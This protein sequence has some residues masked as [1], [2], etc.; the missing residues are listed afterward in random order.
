M[1]P[2]LSPVD[3]LSAAIRRDLR[4]K[5]RELTDHVASVKISTNASVRREHEVAIRRKEKSIGTLTAK[6]L[7]AHQVQSRE[8][9]VNGFTK[10]SYSCRLCRAN[11]LSGFTS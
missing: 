5:Q 2:Q 7:C 11:A 8:L 6:L 3:L 1:N 4:R 9:R 10:V